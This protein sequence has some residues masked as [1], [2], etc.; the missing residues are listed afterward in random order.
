MPYDC[1]LLN[2]ENAKQ[3]R[4]SIPLWRVLKGLELSCMTSKDN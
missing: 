4:L 1:L 2:C 3:N